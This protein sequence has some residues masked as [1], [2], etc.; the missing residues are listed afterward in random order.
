ME[1]VESSLHMMKVAAKF[2]VLSS[3]DLSVLFKHSLNELHNV[4]GMSV[5][6]ISLFYT[7]EKQGLERLD[8]LPMVTC[9]SVVEPDFYSC[10]PIIRLLSPTS[11]L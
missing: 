11:D 5:T 3:E 9:K 2:L 7:R 10:A 6:V 4:H 1:C 8:N